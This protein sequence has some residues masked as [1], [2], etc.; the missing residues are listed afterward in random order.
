MGSHWTMQVLLIVLVLSV[1]WNQSTSF[2]ILPSFYFAG[3]STLR[4]TLRKD[5][6]Q[7]AALLTIANRNVTVMCDCICLELKGFPLAPEIIHGVSI[8]RICPRWS[9]GHPLGN[10]RNEGGEEGLKEHPGRPHG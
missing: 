1:L 9:V 2:F 6:C 3:V 4:P 10:L 5:Q 8:K 7:N